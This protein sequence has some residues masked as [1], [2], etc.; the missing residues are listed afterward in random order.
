MRNAAGAWVGNSRAVSLTV[1]S[2]PGIL[3]GGKSYTFNPGTQEF[4]GKAAIEFRSYYPGTTTI[5]ARSAGLPDKTITIT[6][7]GTAGAAGETEP[8]DF[9]NSARWG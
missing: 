2:G 5:T 1:T 7:T 9:A 4:D 8:A 6:T 3:P